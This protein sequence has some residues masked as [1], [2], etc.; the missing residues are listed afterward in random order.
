MKGSSDPKKRS[1]IISGHLKV[2]EVKCELVDEKVS[3]VLKFL[4][5]FNIYSYTTKFHFEE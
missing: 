3:N 5:T 1:P 2:V 4:K